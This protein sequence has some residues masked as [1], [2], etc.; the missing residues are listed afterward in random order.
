MRII[1][2]V[3]D[4][5]VLAR[6][7]ELQR[8]G[9]NPRPVLERI[10][11]DF[12]DIERDVFATRGSSIGRPWQPLSESTAKADKAHRGRWRYHGGLLNQ[13]GRLQRSLTVPRAA[14]SK[15]SVSRSSLTIGSTH[16]LAHLHQWGT[17]ER[18]VRTWRGKPLAKPRTAGRLP[19][20][21][22]VSVTPEDKTRWRQFISDFVMGFDEPRVGL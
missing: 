7:A 6:L 12:L 11:D 16:P 20:R 14:R 5:K 1:V 10:A 4:K 13:S 2:T 9:V 15:R 21:T 18:E 19:A 8:R 3:D 22:L 17:K